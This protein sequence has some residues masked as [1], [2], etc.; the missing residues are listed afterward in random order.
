MFVGSK[1]KAIFYILLTLVGFI[2][3][4]MCLA[5]KELV[6]NPPEQLNLLE[7]IESS[8]WL[9]TTA[10]WILRNHSMTLLNREEV[11]VVSSLNKRRMLSESEIGT[12]GILLFEFATGE[13]P[14]IRYFDTS[15]SFTHAF[16]QSPGVSYILK[17]YLS[18]YSDTSKVKFDS[19]HDLLDVRY[20]FSPVYR[21]IDFKTWDFSLVQHFA[22]WDSKSFSQIYLGSF[23]A[24]IQYLTDTNIR[25]HV[26][27]STS[28]KS[29]FAGFGKRWQR[30][31]PLETTTQHITFELSTTDLNALLEF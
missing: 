26:W 22:T 5:D 27:N 10:K 11:E 2:P 21:P 31:L 4:K 8:K 1:M 3:A 25:V 7:K 13:G 24:D 19:T 15:H 16:V 14:A 6:K 30:P 18:S 12:S 23:N 9:N 17:K 28:K 20:Q 29:L